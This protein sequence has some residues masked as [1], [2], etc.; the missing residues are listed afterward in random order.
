MLK[1]TVKQKRKI[2]D[3]V[4]LHW[5]TNLFLAYA[6]LLSRDDIADTCCE[7]CKKVS[8]NDDPPKCPVFMYTKMLSCDGTQWYSVR[9]FIDYSQGKKLIS[10]TAEFLKFLE[11][12]CDKWLK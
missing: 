9:D 3:K 12:I 2:C 5:W 6:D 7:F 8:C 4:I 1:I 10:A 11:N